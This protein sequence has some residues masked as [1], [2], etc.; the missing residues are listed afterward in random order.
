MFSPAEVP[1][2]FW[3]F[4]AWMTL[5][6]SQL[7]TNAAEIAQ[8]APAAGKLSERYRKVTVPLVIIAGSEDRLVHTD[9]HSM[10][11]Y[12]ELPQADFRL[13]EGMGHMLYHLA[14]DQVMDAIDAAA[15]LGGEM[16]GQPAARHGAGVAT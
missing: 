10:R 3:R 13:L 14:P 7:R 5:R 9:T 4:P 15:R 2:R 8:V 11:L 16:G 1:A 6:P 12:A